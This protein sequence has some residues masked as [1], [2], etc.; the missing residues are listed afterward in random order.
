MTHDG[1]GDGE[2]SRRSLLSGLAG[3]ALLG[4]GGLGGAAAV[5]DADAVLGTFEDGLDGWTAAAGETLSRVGRRNWPPAVTGRSVALHVDAAGTARPAVRRPLGG[6]DL[7]AAPYLLAEATP[8]V[9]DGTDAPVAF[10]FRLRDGVDGTLLAASE[11]VTVR[12]AAPGRIFWDASD[13]PATTFV[14]AT[15]LEVAWWTEGELDRTYR[16][17]VVVDDIRATAD[18]TALEAVRFRVAVRHLEA[19]HGSY[20]R[21]EVD[22]RDGDRERGRFVFAGGATVPYRARRTTEGG[23][24]VT[25]GGD[26]YLFGGGSA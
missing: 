18:R 17:E 1:D 21:T 7:A 20:R 25:L 4:T 19:E 2:R 5:P 12:Q 24:R 6:V 11:P 10:A 3:A 22:A 16:G 15:V 9:V 23:Y 26:T 13:L 8:G 14:A